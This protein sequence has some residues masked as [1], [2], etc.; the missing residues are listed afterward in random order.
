[1]ATAW[2]LGL[3]VL[4]LLWYFPHVDILLRRIYGKKTTRRPTA[5]AAAEDYF[6]SDAFL[7]FQWGIES[8]LIPHVAEHVFY[9][10]ILARLAQFD[11]MASSSEELVDL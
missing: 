8:L 11:G 9:G 3:C 2:P 6:T 10:S 5:C 7:R 1:M 4:A